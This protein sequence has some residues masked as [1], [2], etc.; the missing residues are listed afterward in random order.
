MRLR[1]CS[2]DQPTTPGQTRPRRARAGRAPPRAMSARGEPASSPFPPTTYDATAYRRLS[3]LTSVPSIGSAWAAPLETGRETV[4]RLLV[5]IPGGA[6][7][8]SAAHVA[9][10]RLRATLL[11]LAL[12]L[13]LAAS[14]QRTA[15]H[16]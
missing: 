14:S 1:S 7:H 9:R 4:S 13:R 10:W 12:L 2:R 6:V 16:L 11:P 15:T 8:T 3:D 5:R